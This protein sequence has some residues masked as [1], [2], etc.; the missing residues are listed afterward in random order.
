MPRKVTGDLVLAQV[1]LSGGMLV[2]VMI[3]PDGLGANAGISYYGIHHGTVVPYAVAVIG[4]ALFT[5]RALRDM[6][7]VL[8]ASAHVRGTADCLAAMAW[9]VVL[10]PYSLNTLFDWA[11]TMLG[12]ALFF[13]QL[14]LTARLLSWSGG[15]AWM[16]C[17]LLVEFG[18]GVVA[19]VFVLTKDGFLIQAQLVFQLAFTMALIRRARPLVAAAVESAPSER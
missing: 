1:F 16:R 13:L 6:A 12:A 9:G 18:S 19:G 10:T 11:H 2:C 7:P 4:S 15:D 17:L 8:P 3:R 5:R 14:V